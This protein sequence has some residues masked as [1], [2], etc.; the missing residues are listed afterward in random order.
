MAC[1]TISSCVHDIDREL[2]WLALKM[3]SDEKVSETRCESFV[4]A[5]D[6]VRIVWFV[7]RG[8]LIMI[9]HDRSHPYRRSLE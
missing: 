5:D 2:K 4:R 6:T 3:K 8:Y 1:S 9:M 7:R